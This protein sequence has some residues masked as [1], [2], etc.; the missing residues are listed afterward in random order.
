VS[1]LA[2]TIVVVALIGAAVALTITGHDGT[3]AWAA[4]GGYAGGAGVQKA[5][6]AK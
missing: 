2:H 6:E 1:L 5:A 4:I 3:P